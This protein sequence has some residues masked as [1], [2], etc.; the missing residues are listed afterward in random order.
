MRVLIIKMSS[1]G[2]VIH[3]LP[4]LTDAGKAIKDISFD[5]IVEEGF[6]E[7]PRWHPLVK[8][9]FPIAFRR[10][11]KKIF[12]SETR[13]SIR[14]F[15]QKVRENKYDLIIDA[16]GLLKSALIT[17]LISG[18]KAGLDF[19]SARESLASLCY[20]KKFFVDKKQHAVSR[21]RQLFSQALG[22][23][24]TDDIP[25]YGVNRNQFALSK[26]DI[27]NYVLFLHGTT[28]TTK[29]WPEEYWKELAKIARDQGFKV[30]LPWGNLAEYERAL[31]IAADNIAVEVLPKLTLKE[32]ATVLA[33]AKVIVAVDTGLG[34]LAAALDVPTVSLYGP[35]NAD[36]TGA[37]GRSQYHLKANFPCSPCLSRKCI[38]PNAAV[39][40]E[41]PPC[42]TTLPP[43]MVWIEVDKLI[44][45]AS[46]R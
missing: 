4:A 46:L 40:S 36:L 41:Q 2:D 44:R 37:L 13:H 15:L 21:T 28:W 33:S 8:N 43:T 12:A 29:H 32:I 27:E 17:S 6:Q 22:Y 7:I 9:I 10:W 3:T 25:D 30:K 34:H 45:N 35:T 24:I 11:R 23:G 26:V 18:K 14:E 20:Q 1:M 16:Q 5:W 39:Y 38:F 31:R 19:K 42:F